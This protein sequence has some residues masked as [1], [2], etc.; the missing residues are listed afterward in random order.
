MNY[1]VVVKVVH[2]F[3]DF[4]YGSSCVLFGELAI[5]ADAVEELSP[6]SELGNNVV[7]VLVCA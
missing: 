5:L 7:F 3:K 2:S 6:R 4:S 1:V